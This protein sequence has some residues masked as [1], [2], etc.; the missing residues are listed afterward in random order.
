MD[1]ELRSGP[2]PGMPIEPTEELCA[3]GCGGVARYRSRSGGKKQLRCSEYT[4]QCPYIRQFNGMM[5]AQAFHEGR[6]NTNH[7]TDEIR[8]KGNRG[9]RNEDARKIRIQRVIDGKAS[10]RQ[11]KRYLIEELKM[12]FCQLC[13]NRGKWEGRPLTLQ[14][15]HID[16]NPKNN[17][18]E[19]LRWLCP[20]CHSQTETWGRRK[21]QRTRGVT[22]AALA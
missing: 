18:I 3:H 13:D 9:K 1:N 22:V 15:D 19:N 2:K 7:L 5:V 21:D 20:N 6:K 14:L 10:F 17:R 8:G 16:G 12:Y 4:T 11:I